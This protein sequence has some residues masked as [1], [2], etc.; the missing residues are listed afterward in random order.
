MASGAAAS[1]DLEQ[2]RSLLASAR[3]SDALVKFVESLGVESLADFVGLVESSK[4]ESQLAELILDKSPEKGSMLQLA[5]LR[6]AWSEASAAIQQQRKRKLEGVAE[7][8]EEPLDPVVAENLQSSWQR[9]Y[10]HRLDI[11]LTPSD[12]LLGRVYR[13]LQRGTA[14]LIPGKITSLFHA[15]LPQPKTEVALHLSLKLQVATEP[16]PVKDL[17]DYYFRL[18]ILANAYCLASSHKVDSVLHPGTQVTFSPLEINLN[19]SDQALQKANN[20][21]APP[22]AQLAWL[23]TRDLHT[24]SKMVEFLRMSYPQ[25][26][27][28]I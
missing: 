27:G 13:E 2:L 3:L 12:S 4:Y 5:R 23:E 8:A 9:L 1:R 25:W 16:G 11:H 22:A 28:L 20:V 10:G 18:R 21:Q 26:R 15:S 17:A 14:S 7:D 6:T 24:R 19:Y